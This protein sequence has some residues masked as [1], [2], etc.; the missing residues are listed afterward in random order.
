MIFTTK[1]V[2]VLESPPLQKIIYPH[3]PYCKCDMNLCLCANS[4]FNHFYSPLLIY[5]FPIN[6]RVDSI[7]NI[8]VVHLV[9]V[10]PTKFS[11]ND[12]HGVRLGSRPKHHCHSLGAPQLYLT[13]SPGFVS[14]TSQCRSVKS[15]QTWLL[16]DFKPP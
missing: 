10:P 1:I 7:K 8:L 14:F 4:Y 6:L 2:T 3:P 12:D 5:N 11:S 9:T 13:I 16:S 15:I